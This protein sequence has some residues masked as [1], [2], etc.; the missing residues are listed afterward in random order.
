[1][2]EEEDTT[3]GQPSLSPG[4]VLVMT[5]DELCTELNSR[6]KSC[7]G[8]T[9]PELQLALLTALNV[10]HVTDQASEFVSELMQIF[11]HEFGI[12]H[13]RASAY[14]PQSNGACERFN[15]TLKTMMRSL[16]AVSYTHLTLPTKRIV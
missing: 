1:M 2:A 8:L 11:L 7:S 9:K 13:V 14:H 5:A 16:T 10:V 15:G 3:G 12:S 4:D 6:G